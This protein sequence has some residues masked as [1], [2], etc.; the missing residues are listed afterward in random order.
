MIL[1]INESKKDAG[2]LS[3]MLYYMGVLSVS[4]TPSGALNEISPV[5]RAVV[6]MN[7]ETISDGEDY[8]KELRSYTASPIFAISNAIDSNSKF[9]FDATFKPE[10]YAA[11]IYNLIADYT[12]KC[13]MKTPG[14]YKLPGIDASVNLQS[15]NCFEKP[16]LLTKT[17]TMILR[18]LIRNYPNPTSARNILKYAFRQAKLPELSNIRT[19]ISII[20]KKFREHYG[21]N[22][23]EFSLREGYRISILKK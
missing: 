12:K 21:K 13:G 8:V 10:V 16:I 5:Y 2:S 3:D 22:L 20:N 19:H 18:A 1:V 23:I 6:I 11:K 15:A 7:P 17:E 4:A 9:I 14:I